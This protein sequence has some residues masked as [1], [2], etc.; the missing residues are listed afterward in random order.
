MDSK[1]TDTGLHERITRI[2]EQREDLRDSDSRL[3]T[4]VWFIEA[5]EKGI[6]LE[7]ITGMDMLK[8][9]RG[10][11][12]T[13]SESIRRSR[14]K[15]QE[16]YPST[17]GKKYRQRHEKEKEVRNFYGRQNGSLF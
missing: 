4:Y 14:Q 13:S 17:R 2:L 9:L 5:R 11:T 3:I 6:E 12:F 7:K 16:K 15:V 8:L 10:D 1:L